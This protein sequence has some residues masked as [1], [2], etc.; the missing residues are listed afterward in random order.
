MDVP[1]VPQHDSPLANKPG[2]MDD[3]GTL[4]GEQGARKDI[5]TRAPVDFKLRYFPLRFENYFF[6]YWYW[7]IPGNFLILTVLDTIYAVRI[8]QLSPRY[9]PFLS[10]LKFELSSWI[11][12]VVALVLIL[13]AFNRWSRSILPTFL[14]LLNKGRIYSHSYDTGV[15][16]EYR[17]FLNAYQSALLSN[18]R[19]I[20]IASSAIIVFVFTLLTW[21]SFLLGTLSNPGGIDPLLLIDFGWFR[22]IW[23]IVNFLG[24]GYF[25]G[26]AAWVMGVTGWYIRK[27]AVNYFDRLSILPSHPDHCGGLKSIGDFCLRMALPIL[28]GTV[29]LGI[30]GF[31]SI[32]EGINVYNVLPDIFLFLFALPLAAIAFFVPLWEIHRTMV[33]RRDADYNKFADC[34]AKLEG[35]IQSSL[36][37]GLLDEARVAREELEIAQ[38]LPPAKSGYPTWP[39]DRRILLTFL[40]PQI[41]PIASLV[42]QIVQWLLKA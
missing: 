39:F 13:P 3:S 36:D 30:L 16:Q 27:F 25:F 38:M 23:Y 6:N 19:Y 29:F 8:A 35:K 18:K 11:L 10:L 41:V 2:A 7:L 33:E 12:L 28:I 22:T 5:I 20:V 31:E 34:V 17:S 9:N 14:V 26:V 40:A 37:K 42:V 32:S 1:S 24:Q 15:A 21:G 4:S